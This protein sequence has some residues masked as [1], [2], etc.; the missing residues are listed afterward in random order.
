M[1][2][3]LLIPLIV[4][5]ILAGYLTYNYYAGVKSGTWENHKLLVVLIDDTEGQVGGGPGAVDMAYVLNFVNGSVTNTTPIYP[6]SMQASNNIS[7]PPDVP[8]EKHLKLV[9]SFYWSNM[10]QDSQYAQE[11]VQQSTGIKTD[12]VVILKPAAV[13]AIISALGPI[14]VNGTLVNGT[15]VNGTLVNGTDINGTL[16]GDDAINFVRS[17]QYHDNMSRGEAVDTLAYAIKNASTSKAK[18]PVLISTITE[19]YSQGNLIVIPPNLF[20]QMITEEGITKIFGL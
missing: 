4:L 14:Y 3:L 17:L 18:M 12:G 6:G 8:K 9:D 16:E 7:A 5:G 13:D 10:T 11:I 1:A 19:Q 20:N 2:Q 15:L